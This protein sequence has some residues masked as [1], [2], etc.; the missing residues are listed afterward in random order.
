MTCCVIDSLLDNNLLEQLALTGGN[1][2]QRFASARQPDA[3]LAHFI[4]ENLPSF[5]S[6][7]ARQIG[8]SAM[9]STG[10]EMY[11]LNLPLIRLRAISQRVGDGGLIG[12]VTVL[13]SNGDD[14]FLF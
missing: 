7:F 8:R 9:L 14:A 13:G 4:R 6:R 5:Q 2:Q 12:R 11:S 1:Y 10:G 3:D